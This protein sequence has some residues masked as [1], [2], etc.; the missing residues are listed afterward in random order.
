VSS[1]ADV[2]ALI[3]THNRCA[4]LS[5][6]VEAIRGQSRPPREII[7]VDNGGP[8]TTTGWLK[9]Q[10]DVTWFR[11]PNLGS[12]GG[13]ARGLSE[14]RHVQSSSVWVMDDD[15]LP[16]PDCLERLLDSPAF[17]EERSIVGSL[18][19]ATDSEGLAFPMPL[20][21]SY[22]GLLDWYSRLT[23]RVAD[24]AREA[25]ALGYFWVCFFNS[26]LFR[27][28]VMDEVGLP[29]AELFI[30]GD[31]VE[32]FLRIRAAGFCTYTVLD[33]VV[34]HPPWRQ[35]AM[36]PWKEAYALRNKVWINREYGR[37]P[38]VKALARA[39]QLVGE[40]RFDLLRPLWDGVAGDLSRRYHLDAM[41]T[42]TA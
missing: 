20:R 9:Q 12:A 35:E 11:Q 39:A 29:R 38:R 22:V 1:P 25:D 17:E 2:A 15:C 28:N 34:R 32:Y 19:L 40:R 36:A 6:C 8:D 13:F 14:A 10:P 41:R 42:G 16:A 26:V 27:K 30:W 33:S 3:V 37:W 5:E 18:V 21:S 23:M 24:I 31:E 4:A 7:V